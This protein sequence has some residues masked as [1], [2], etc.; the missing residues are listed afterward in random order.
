MGRFGEGVPGCMFT[1]D[2]NRTMSSA[3]LL[4]VALYN[5]L[6]M[7]SFLM[8]PPHRSLKSRKTK[9]HLGSEQ[10]V[11]VFA[12]SCLES[13]DEQCRRLIRKQNRTRPLYGADQG[14]ERVQ[15]KYFIHGVYHQPF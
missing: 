9:K 1:Q 11:L 7:L 8:K 4:P 2:S 3:P 15:Q 14:C 6:P 12:K 10:C 5:P 13:L